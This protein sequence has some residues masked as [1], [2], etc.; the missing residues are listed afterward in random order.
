MVRRG[1]AGVDDSHALVEVEFTNLMS[2][3]SLK[4]K[5]I[6]WARAEVGAEKTASLDFDECGYPNSG[7][8]EIEAE[9]KDH[10]SAQS[11]SKLG[12]ADL[13]GLLYLIARSWDLGRMIAWHGQLGI[14]SNLGPL[15]KTDALVLAEAA[16]KAKG[17]EYDD[18]KYQFAAILPN[19]SISDP[20]VH[21][22][23][24]RFFESGDMYVRRTALTSLA[25]IAHP[26][27]RELIEIL[28]NTG[29]E[30]ARITCLSVIE[31]ELGD[32]TLL[33]KYIALAESLPGNELAQNLAE[34][35]ERRSVRPP[36]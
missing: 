30:F 13:D 1:G 2:F 22:V 8:S 35:I 31:H 15:S 23:L 24:L 36:G 18:A 16:E 32:D 27:T 34:A 6:A 5:Y 19:V 10:I 26:R 7:W 11:F 9:F 17:R 4:E 25:K 21:D 20:R 29:D 12:A 28:W 33:D 3:A 14:L